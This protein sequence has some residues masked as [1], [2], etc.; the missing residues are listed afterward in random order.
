MIVR[1]VATLLVLT[2]GVFAASAPAMA[3]PEVRALFVGID[4]Y[5]WSSTSVDGAGFKDLKG[6]VGDSQRFK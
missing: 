4:T 6:A 5:R 1:I 3:R 2:A